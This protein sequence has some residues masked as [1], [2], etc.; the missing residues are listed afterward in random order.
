[1]KKLMLWI[2]AL[3]AL[4]GS[5]LFAQDITGTWQGTL[6]APKQELRTV[7][8]ISKTD[9]GLKAVLYSIDQGG[10][11]FSGTV[12]LE[13]PIVK[14]SIPGIGGSYEGKLDGDAIALTGTFSQGP[15]KL[16]LNLKH[17]NDD[18]AWEIPSPPVPV[19]AMP[20]DADPAFDVT[21]IKPS[22]P[23]SPGKGINVRGRQ[24]TTLN[25]S[26]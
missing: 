1:M 23:G 21:V 13:S 24:L 5:A 4:P 10:Q 11:G 16:P 19:K 15:G 9:A 12:T 25:F 3:V 6:Q 17:V 22:E 8:K 14:I 20:A 26:L 2:I 18:A 7:I